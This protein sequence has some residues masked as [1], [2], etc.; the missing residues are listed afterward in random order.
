MQHVQSGI[1]HQPLLQ[2]NRRRIRWGRT[3][4]QTRGY[5]L[6][7]MGLALGLS[8]VLWLLVAASAASEPA[9]WGGWQL[10]DNSALL[11][12]AVFL[13]GLA[14]TPLSDLAGI[15]FTID[16]FNG[17]MRTGRWELLCLSLAPDAIVRAKHAAARLRTWRVTVLVLAVRLSAIVLL[18]LHLTVVHH[19][20]FGATFL[21]SAR[22]ML[23]SGSINSQI[24]ILLQ[25]GLLLMLGAYYLAAPLWRLHTST[26][27]GLAISAHIRNPGMTALAGFLGIC[28]VWGAEIM[29]VSGMLFML[30]TALSVFSVI[31]YELLGRY[32]TPYYMYELF[33]TDMVVV[34]ALGA[35]LL[36][37]LSFHLVTR[38]IGLHAARS[39]VL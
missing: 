6:L 13:L 12:L 18:L 21:E 25:L 15:L 32:G 23:S 17:E 8:L 35:T 24:S 10:Y 26:A 9:P 37:L 20:V 11:A 36:A 5:T 14:I 16:S 29:I 7:V 30:V 4:R 3:P 38:Y 33:S 19:A 27:L 39:R 31:W 34:L 2:L 1:S 28:I 22:L